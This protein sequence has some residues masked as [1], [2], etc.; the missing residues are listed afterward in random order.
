VVWS[1]KSRAD[2]EAEA[3]KGK[4]STSMEA[5]A[6]TAT[7]AEMAISRAPELEVASGDVVRLVLQFL[8]ENRLFG[9][10]RAL[11][12]EA[13]VGLNAVDSA[14]ALVADIRHGRWDAVLQQ[15]KALECSA[16]AMMELYELVA[17]E[18]MEMREADVAVQ[19]LRATPA[20]AHMKHAQPERYLRLERL[21]QRPF[22]AAEAFAGVDK[23][24]RRN[25]VADMFRNEVPAT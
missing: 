5:T 14:E 4:D 24:R 2:A 3:A 6:A 11:Q 16:A 19:L 9:A 15:T 1:T 20:M 18:M 23:Q 8:R 7:T 25:D 17:L 21:A 13:Q 22:D 10:M 12:E